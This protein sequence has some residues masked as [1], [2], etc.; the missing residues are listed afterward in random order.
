MLDNFNRDLL[1][2]KLE[3]LTKKILKLDYVKD[4][5]KIE[6]LKENIINL[7]IDTFDKEED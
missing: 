1:L 3:D 7:L 6:D 5:I 4:K 2:E